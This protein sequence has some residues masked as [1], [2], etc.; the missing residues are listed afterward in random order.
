MALRVYGCAGG[1]ALIALAMSFS[2]GL[3]QEKT[4]DAVVAAARQEG[5]LLIYNGTNFPIVRKIAVEMQKEYGI[6][7][8]VLDGR[9]SEIRERIRIEQSTNRTVASLSYSGFTTL[10]TQ[11]QEGAFQDHGTLPNA[12]GVAPELASKG[13]VLLGSVGLF[14]V[15][16]NTSLVTGADIPT[17]WHDLTKP[18]WQGKILSDDFRAAGA[19]NVW[20]EAT[21]NAFGCSFHEKMAAQKPVFSRNFPDSERRVARGEYPIY[22]PFN[23]SE[24]ASLR[25]LPIKALVPSEGAAYVPMGAAILKDAPHPNAARVYLNFLLSDRGQSTLAAEGFRPAKPGFESSAVPEVAPLLAGKLL[26]TT[27]PGKLDE[28]TRIA[29]E[30]YK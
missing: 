17:S 6:S 3:A 7:V 27:T 18:Q 16:Y 26:G 4:W 1:A 11:S 14:V 13:Q 2:P 25:G 12:N 15:M 23:V 19:G 8:D 20:F 21:Y 9:A 28:M 22:L 5:T 30:L 29:T 10:F 24:Y